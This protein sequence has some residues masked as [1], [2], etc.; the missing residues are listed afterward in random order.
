MVRHVRQWLVWILLLG[1]GTEI[2]LILLE[3][4]DGASQFIP[5][6]LIAAALVAVVWHM[7]RPGSIS[8]R[9]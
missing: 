6:E 4:Y 2:E 9:T 8:L 7:S 1:L 3:H 5:L